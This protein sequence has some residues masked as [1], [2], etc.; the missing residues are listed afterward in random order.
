M[1]NRKKIFTGLG[2][3]L[4]ILTVFGTYNNPDRKSAETDSELEA[5][6]VAANSTMQEIRNDVKENQSCFG[7]ESLQNGTWSE[8]VIILRNIQENFRSADRE[9]I[10]KLEKYYQENQSVLDN[11]TKSMVENS[12]RLYRSDSYT[13]L[14]NAYDRYFTANIEWHKFFRD[15][16]GIKGVDNMTDEELMSTQPLAQEVVSAKENLQLKTNTFPN[17]L[18]ENFDKEFVQPLTSYA[19]NPKQ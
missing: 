10:E 11:E 5:I 9:N 19:E 15:V 17:Y 6:L 14:V 2:I 12:L 7:D 18:H 1:S 4:L 16:I 8:C 13:D 3:A